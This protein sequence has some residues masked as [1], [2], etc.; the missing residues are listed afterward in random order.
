ME[1]GQKPHRKF[2][3]MRADG[4]AVVRVWNF[5]KDNVRV[6]SNDSLRVAKRDISVF[7]S[8]NE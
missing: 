5:P 3:G 6:A 2:F 8:V 7:S 1:K 4:T